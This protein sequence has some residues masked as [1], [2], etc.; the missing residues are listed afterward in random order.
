MGDD[1]MKNS[2]LVTGASGFAG[3]SLLG[4]LKSEHYHVIPLV[5]TPKKLPNEIILD[6]TDDNFVQKV[7]KLPRVNAIIHLGAKVDWKAT[8][9][10]LFVPNVLATTTL[11]NWAKNIGAYFVFA[12]T[13]TVCGVNNPLITKDTKPNPDTNYGYSKWLAEEIINT[14]GVEY[15]ILRISGIYG[16]DGPQH[17]GINNAITGALQGKPPIQFGKG[18]IMRNYICVGD[19][20]KIIVDCL[21]KKVTGVHLVAGPEPLSIAEMLK[22]ICEIFLPGKS[23]IYRDGEKGFNQIVEHSD[24]LIPGRKFREALEHIKMGVENES[25]SSTW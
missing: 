3:R 12:S 8:K 5:R 20:S 15:L 4:L 18:D 9:S 6:F 23:P 13:A 21:K 19:L 1:L 2:V 7:Q 10:D 17:L 11:V 14:S 16:R 22:T 24:A 25:R